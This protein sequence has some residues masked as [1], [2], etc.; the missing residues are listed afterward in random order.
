MSLD[1]K[2]SN[3]KV[4][5]K[6]LVLYFLKDSI[7]NRSR[8]KIKI[9]CD[10]STTSL[11]NLSLLLVRMFYISSNPALYFWRKNNIKVINNNNK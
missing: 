9:N 2:I 1:S 6:S 8:K 11:V 7:L 3:S 5:F 10:L 4:I